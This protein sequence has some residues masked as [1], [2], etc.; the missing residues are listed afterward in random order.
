MTR[1]RHFQITY[2]FNKKKLLYGEIHSQH[3]DAQLRE[4]AE[5]SGLTHVKWEELPP[6]P[7]GAGLPA[8][9]AL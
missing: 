2:C 9:A 4:H 1:P 6:P 3:S 8:K 5:K 7:V